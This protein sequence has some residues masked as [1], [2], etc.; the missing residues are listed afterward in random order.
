MEVA[1][2]DI[3]VAGQEYFPADLAHVAPL[4]Q[5]PAFGREDAPHDFTISVRICW[6]KAGPVR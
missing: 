5:R 4:Q 6:Q 3:T 1:F 2:H